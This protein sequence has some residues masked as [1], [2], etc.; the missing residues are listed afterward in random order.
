LAIVWLRV[1]PV[2][3][4]AQLRQKVA[5]AHQST[6]VLVIPCFKMGG[7]A[8]ETAAVRNLPYWTSEPIHSPGGI[9][10]LRRTVATVA[11]LAIGGCS[12]SA[13]LDNPFGRNGSSQAQLAAYAANSRFP[14]TQ[15]SNDLHATAVVARSNNNVTIF[16]AGGQPIIDAR[17]W[18]NGEFVAHVLS[19]P[20]H[21]SVSLPRQAF[22]NGQGQSLS[23]VKTPAM[24]VQLQ[25]P[26]KFYNLQGPVWE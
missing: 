9:F 17:V 15:P 2:E 16:N 25:T 3:F 21:G 13:K 19:I 24:S 14:S 5:S 18:V 22:Y 8:A 4:A 6:A 11:V 10:M 1:N 7:L 12:S 23:E 26:D 20:A